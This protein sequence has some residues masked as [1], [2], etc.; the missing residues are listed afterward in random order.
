MKPSTDRQEQPHKPC[1][2]W[3]V[4]KHPSTFWRDNAAGHKQSRR[5]LKVHESIGLDELYLWDLR[6]LLDQMVEPLSIILENTP[7]HGSPS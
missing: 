6:E 4:F 7:V 1:S 2:S 5:F 3:G